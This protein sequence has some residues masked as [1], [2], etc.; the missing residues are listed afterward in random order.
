MM[1][2]Q[3]RVPVR[4]HQLPTYIKDNMY[5]VHVRL[6]NKQHLNPEASSPDGATTA[7]NFQNGTVVRTGIPALIIQS[8]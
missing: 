1:D 2:A 7:L 8:V 5:K 4:I 6:N 3:S